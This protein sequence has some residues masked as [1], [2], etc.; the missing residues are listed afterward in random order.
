M[1][2]PRA[3]VVGT[4][5]RLSLLWLD[6]ISQA[7]TYCTK[8]PCPQAAATSALPCV[9][10]A[11]GRAPGA[12]GGSLMGRTSIE[13]TD[14]SV[15]PIRARVGGHGDPF[16][17]LRHGHYCE[18]ISPGCA[19]CY[20]SRMQRRFGMPEFGEQRQR[21]DVEVYFELKA[22]EEVLRR[23]KPTRWF[24]CDMTDLFGAW[25]PDEWI[26]RCLA[27]MALTPQ[28]THLVLTKRAER[29][30]D[31]SQ[32]IANDF[33]HGL[34]RAFA[35]HRHWRWPLSNVWWGCSVENQKYADE[36]I[37]LL[38]QTP[39]AVRFVSAEPLLGP[40]DLARW[41]RIQGGGVGHCFDIN[42]EWWHEPGTC[43]GPICK[44][45]CCGRGLDWVIVGGES[46][47]GARPCDLAWIRSIVQQCRT[48]GVPCFVKQL[49]A[50]PVEDLEKVDVTE[51]ARF[52]PEVIRYSEPCDLRLHDRK[53]GDPAEWP[54]DLRVRETPGGSCRES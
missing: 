53:G 42:N 20:S 44:G 52:G 7:R 3:T 35:N 50:N 12:E 54:E 41:L 25:V 18:K 15:N 28:H 2:P 43:M 23:Q 27:V 5:P 47:P 16:A 39:A 34:A 49:G 11:T 17:P 4:A 48:A 51:H 40:V 36:R 13:W 21:D 37:P 6:P 31:Y 38:L 29:M 8:D 1:R 14:F 22:L 10:K 30:C 32:R 26:D 24:W 45:E 19:H 46:G 9:E 33:D